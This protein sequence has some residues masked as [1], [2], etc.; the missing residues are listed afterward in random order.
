VV[1][2]LSTNRKLYLTT[3]HYHVEHTTGEQSFPADTVLIRPSVQQEEVDKNVEGM[4]ARFR[5][6]S[7][8]N[9][10][11]LAGVKLRAPDMVFDRE[12]KL[13]LGGVTARLMWLGAAHTKGDEVIFVEP[14]STLISGDV[15]Q[16]RLVPRVNRGEGT[17]KGWLAVLDKIEPLK[18]RFV[19]PDHGDLGDTSL[20]AKQRGFMVDLESRSLALKKQ[21]VSVSDA[22]KQL[23]AE[24]TKK[25]P[26]WASMDLVVMFVERVYE[27]N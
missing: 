23:T 14:D 27:E 3:T 5:T 1:N 8:R 26:D 12:M 22:G 25:Y 10:D 15:V 16:D 13:D 6:M 9:R 4:M 19:I 18:P 20:I 11:L 17:P 2:K 24:F 21:G 7:E